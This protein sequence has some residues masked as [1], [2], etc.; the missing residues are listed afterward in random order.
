MRQ[1]TC[2]ALDV[3]VRTSPFD[4]AAIPTELGRAENLPTSSREFL[5]TNTCRYIVVIEVFRGF[6][7]TM[8][9]DAKIYINF[10]CA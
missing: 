1:I 6:A 9:A 3:Y 10:P 4:N 7:H 5:V 8:Q 2:I